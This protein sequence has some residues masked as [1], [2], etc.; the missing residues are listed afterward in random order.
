MGLM[1]NRAMTE[2]R[3]SKELARLKSSSIPLRG[4]LRL[5][6][7]LYLSRNGRAS[8]LHV[9]RFGVGTYYGA[10]YIYFVYIP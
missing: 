7:D 2:R 3:E 6:E 5:A 9:T 4:I 1:F 8:V 10:T